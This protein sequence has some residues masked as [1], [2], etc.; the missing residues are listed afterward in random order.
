MNKN[1]IP[2]DKI[3]YE[4]CKAIYINDKFFEQSRKEFKGFLIEAELLNKLKKKLNYDSLKYLI[5]KNE[6]F[7]NFIKTIRKREKID[8]IKPKK[9]IYYFCKKYHFY[10][11]IDI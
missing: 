4:L 7:Q 10:I 8:L 6:T 3:I 2:S 11:I 9:Y 1:E 5:E